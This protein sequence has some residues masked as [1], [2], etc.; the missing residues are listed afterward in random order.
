MTRPRPPE[1]MLRVRASGHRH[2]CK[3]CVYYDRTNGGRCTEEYGTI[4][5]ST[6]PND[7]GGRWADYIF[8]ED[9]EE[10]KATYAALILEHGQS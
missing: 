6:T 2:S 7:A 3:G 9:T 8:I 1:E 10:A 4:S 5:C